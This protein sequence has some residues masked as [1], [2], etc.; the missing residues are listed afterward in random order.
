M[1]HP[2]HVLHSQG[3]HLVQRSKVTYARLP[4]PPHSQD[5]VELALGRAEAAATQVYEELIG[6]L[7]LE[8]AVGKPLNAPA[9]VNAAELLG[10]VKGVSSGR[11]VC[12]AR[13]PARA[14]PTC[15]ERGNSLTL[16]ATNPEQPSSVET[17]DLSSTAPPTSQPPSIR[18]FR[19]LGS[20]VIES[21]QPFEEPPTS[22]PWEGQQ[23]EVVFGLVCGGFA[24]ANYNT[25]ADMLLKPWYHRHQQQQQQQ[26]QQPWIIN[27]IDI[28]GP[29]PAQPPLAAAGPVPRPQ[30]PPWGRWL[31]RDTNPCL[32]FQRIGE[33]KQPSL[34]LCS[35]TDLKALLP[36]GKE[37]QQ[38]YKLVNDRLPKV[39]QRLHRA[40]EYRRGIDG[41]ARNNA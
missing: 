3:Q 5:S 20:K 28:R 4:K 17:A 27:I 11:Q 16:R 14:Q 40:A 29:A 23:F 22:D 21:D 8:Q 39:R 32:N 19:S 24:A 31:D 6:M 1:P 2:R 12:T 34:E 41:R 26:Q 9:G 37:Y 36:I 18:E 30:A 33:S 13:S 7:Q 35:W 10:Q 15:S 25:D 38:R